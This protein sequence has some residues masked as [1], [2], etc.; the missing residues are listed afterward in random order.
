MTTEQP[1]QHGDVVR[2]DSGNLFCYHNR[3]GWFGPMINQSSA[4][5]R[6]PEDWLA[7]P[8]ILLVRNQQPVCEEA[9]ELERLRT[10]LA[11]ARERESQLRYALAEISDKAL[12]AAGVTGR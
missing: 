11:Q 2:D 10:D 1:W 9:R 5:G 8:L 3:Y 7:P 4:R 6:Q 12:Q